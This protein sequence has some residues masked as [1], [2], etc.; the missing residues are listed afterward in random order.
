MKQN[1][2]NGM[3]LVSVIINNLG[4]MINADVNAKKLFIKAYM[5]KDL[6]G[7]RVILS[8]NAINHVLQV[9]IQTMKTVSA[10][11]NS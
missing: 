8:V 3:K 2:Y 1:T 11:K 10:E 5:V 4:M 9:S 7:I 6:F